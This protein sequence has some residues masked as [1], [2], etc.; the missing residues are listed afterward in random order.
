MNPLLYQSIKL[1]EGVV[2][3]AF[4]IVFCVILYMQIT[5]VRRV[6]RSDML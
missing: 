5:F 1:G 6:G 3:T 4:D 2:H